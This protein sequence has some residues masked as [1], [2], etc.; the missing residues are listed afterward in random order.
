MPKPCQPASPTKP[1]KPCKPTSAPF[2][3]GR[4]LQGLRTAYSG[5]CSCGS[6]PAGSCSCPSGSCWAASAARALPPGSGSCSCPTAVQRVLQARGA[7]R[8]R[9][10]QLHRLVLVGAARG[11]PSDLGRSAWA[12]GPN[13]F[14]VGRSAWAIR[15]I[16]R[17]EHGQAGAGRP[18]ISQKG[19]FPAI[20][21]LLP[22]P[23]IFQVGERVKLI[24]PTQTPS[25]FFM[26]STTSL[27]QHALGSVAGTELMPST[28]GAGSR[29]GVAGRAG[30]DAIGCV[31]SARGASDRS[32][33]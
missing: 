26:G 22:G 25:V 28:V 3:G 2:H 18:R 5:S 21:R 10:L 11:G 4:S 24:S 8:A 1:C 29:A 30:P 32:R 6:C 20:F 12:I 23:A 9:A 19:R 27:L 31:P 33:R 13:P 7:A 16:T 17:L 15:P 14:G